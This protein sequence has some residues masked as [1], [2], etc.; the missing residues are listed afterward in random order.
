MECLTCVKLMAAS[1]H[2]H[3]NLLPP[4]S[5]HSLFCSAECMSD[6]W[7]F[8]RTLHT[9]AANPSSEPLHTQWSDASTESRA[10][11]SGQQQG[12]QGREGKRGG[13]GAAQ[14]LGEICTKF[15]AQRKEAWTVVSRAMEYTPTED[16][17]VSHEID[18]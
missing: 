16:D 18:V 13:Q 6:A 10:G 2:E 12:G 9:A 8:H 15:P 4:L 17:V 5:K 11:A 7:D 1:E 14:T 3:T